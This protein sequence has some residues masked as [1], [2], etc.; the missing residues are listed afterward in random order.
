MNRSL[1]EILLST[2]PL[3]KTKEIIMKKYE[4]VWQQFEISK[5]INDYPTR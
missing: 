2:A 5:K 4:V 1:I 3:K